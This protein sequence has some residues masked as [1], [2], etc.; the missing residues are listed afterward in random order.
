M[1]K[2]KIMPKIINS[3]KKGFD[4]KDRS[5]EE[6]DAIVKRMRQPGYHRINT[7]LIPD[8]TPLEK[9]KYEICQN[10]LAYQQE[11]DLSEKEMGKI[12]GIKPAKKLECLLFCHIENFSLDELVEYASQL[13][14][15]FHLEITPEKSLLFSQK[16]ANDR[17]RKHA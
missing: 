15:P 5:W 16:S 3:T 17:P 1:T 12:L 4:S 7:V 2:N 13:F 14:A 8:A 6:V 9:S 10:I 11:N